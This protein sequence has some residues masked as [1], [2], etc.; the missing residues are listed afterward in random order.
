MQNL[1]YEWVDFPK[2]ELKLGRIYLREGMGVMGLKIVCR[3]R[4]RELWGSEG[5]SIG[6]LREGISDLLGD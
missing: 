5:I 3:Q 4:R 2:F 6:R 1:M